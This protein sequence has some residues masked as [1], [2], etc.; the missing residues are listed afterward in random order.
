MR[1]NRVKL[2]FI[3]LCR[4]VLKT[5]TSDAA[6]VKIMEKEKA[7]HVNIIINVLFLPRHDRHSNTNLMF[8]FM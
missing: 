3:N 2:Y 4:K 8:N 7:Y 5:V 1:I 6:S